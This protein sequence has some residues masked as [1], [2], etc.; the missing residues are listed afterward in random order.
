MSDDELEDTTL[1]LEVYS[2]GVE[3]DIFDISTTLAAT[4]EAI[5]AKGE[6]DRS[7]KEGRVYKLVRSFST[8]SAAKQ[9]GLALPMFSPKS[10]SDGKASMSRF[11][12]EPYKD[13]LKGLSEQYDLFRGR[14]IKALDDLS[15]SVAVSVDRTVL[16]RVSPAYDPVTGG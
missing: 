1:G 8:Y 7:V 14:L 5:A 11:S 10:L 15:S 2:T 9:F 12:G 6:V 4:Y 3:E 13:V 16:L